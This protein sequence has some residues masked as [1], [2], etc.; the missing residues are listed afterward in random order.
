VGSSSIYLG[1]LGRRYGT[2]LP[3][4][5]S[6][7]H[8]EYREAE[9][10]GLRISVWVDA[11]DDFQGDQLAFV[12]EVRLFHTTGRY[13]GPLDLATSV[14]ARLRDIASEDLSPWVKLGDVVFRAHTVHDDGRKVTVHAS[15]HSAEAAA[16]FEA[17]RPGTWAGKRETRL[18]YHGLSHAVRAQSVVTRVTASRATGVELVLERASELERTG[19]SMSFSVNGKTYSGDDIT[20]ISLRK[21]LFGEKAPRGLL[22]IG[23]SIG[24]PLCQMPRERLPAETHRAVFCLLLT[25]ALVGSARASRVTRLQVSPRGPQGHRVLLEW[26]GRGSSGRGGEQRQVEGYWPAS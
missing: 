11:E 17:L 18:T 10:L 2:L 14:A 15:V 6:A 25:E 22:S 4:R 3:S 23:G 21:A 26:T 19:L 9:R 5:L 12:Q 8:T 7:T 20:E 1:I 13:T 24:D 16:A